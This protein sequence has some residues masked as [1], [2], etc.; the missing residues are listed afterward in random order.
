MSF[1]Y[2]TNHN[3]PQNYPKQANSLQQQLNSPGSPA[4]SQRRESLVKPTWHNVCPGQVPPDTLEK[5]NKLT[6]GERHQ[7]QQLNQHEGAQKAGSDGNG[8]NVAAGNNNN[9]LVAQAGCQRRQVELFDIFGKV[10]HPYH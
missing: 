6:N 7:L 2:V 9:P 5:L 4:L 3:S 1:S 8:A 10:N